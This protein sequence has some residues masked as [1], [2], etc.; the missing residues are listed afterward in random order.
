MQ[1]QPKHSWQQ[2]QGARLQLALL[3]HFGQA[4]LDHVRPE[5]QPGRCQQV[6]QRQ[7]RHAQHLLPSTPT[8]LRL[9]IPPH[10]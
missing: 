7:H 9:F 2:E 8:K 6:A 3:H 1:G 5:V 10:A 4:G